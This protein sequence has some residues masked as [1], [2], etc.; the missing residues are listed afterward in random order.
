VLGICGGLQMLGE[1]IRDDAGV[2]GSADGLGLLALETAFAAV[3]RTELTVTRFASLPQ[4][5]AALSGEPLTG[6]QIR[7]GET[8]PRQSVD[9]ALPGGLGFVAGAVLGIYVHGLF[10]SPATVQ[11][12][13]GAMP[14]RSLDQAFDE[15]ADALE[16]HVDVDALLEATAR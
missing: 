16:E 7:H 3:K 12:L 6:Y 13:L 2:D 14:A 11:A 10:E 8:R 4:P 5:W 1:R 9:E 15:L